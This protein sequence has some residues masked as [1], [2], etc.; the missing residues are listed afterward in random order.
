MRTP[1]GVEFSETVPVDSALETGK[2]LLKLAGMLEEEV[3]EPPDP[4]QRLLPSVD[5]PSTFNL[6]DPEH[7]DGG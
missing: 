4:R 1:T 7:L 6:H 3:S 2:H 5:G